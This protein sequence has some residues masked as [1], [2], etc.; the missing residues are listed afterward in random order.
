MDNEKLDDA[1]KASENTETNVEETK[2]FV[3]QHQLYHDV[4]DFFRTIFDVVKSIAVA[5][6]VAWTLTTFVIANAVVPS[7][8]MLNTIDIGSRLLG[9]R[10]HYKLGFEPKNGDIVIFKDPDQSDRI[11]I[12]RCI[13]VGGDKVELIPN[14]DGTGYVLV[15]GQAI[16]EPYLNEPMQVYDY[17]EYNVPKD[18]YFFMGDNRN[19]SFDA[20]FWKNTYVK[21]E[22]LIS[23]V[24]FQYWK[25]FK[26]FK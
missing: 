7:G 2:S 21:K 13:G 11:L 19:D 15:N 14:G 5:Y 10:L 25:G 9:S 8:S 26:T 24:W 22:N 23:N 3:E 12:K 16:D 1:E 17:K 20:R 4:L 6:I 18:C